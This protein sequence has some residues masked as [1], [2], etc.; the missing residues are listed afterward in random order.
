[1]RED[2]SLSITGTMSAIVTPFTKDGEIDF[3]ALEILVSG[4]IDAG[5]D[6][7]VPC[8]TTGETPALSAEEFAQVVRAVVR[9]VQGRI[10]VIAGTGSNSTKKTI[11]TTRLAKELG[12]DAALVVVPY[13]NKPGPTMQVAHF[14]SVA[15]EGGLPVVLYNV[16]GRTGINM[17]AAVTI[18]L[19]AHP[20]VIAVKEASGDLSQVQRI[21]RETK[22]SEFTVLSGD[23]ALALPMY[24]VGAH[25]VV[26]V[27]GNVV[28]RQ[29]ASIWTAW[30]SGKAEEASRTNAQLFPLFDAL[31]VETNPVPAKVALSLLGRMQ[32]TVRQPLGP[33]TSETIDA[34]RSVLRGLELL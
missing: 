28:P 10:P 27:A 33:A 34:M 5:M 22:Q 1:M 13:Y 15:N 14:Q 32:P 7:I 4:Q 17:P 31:F 29:M 3:D 11:E 26:S 21:L 12:A 25:G 16:P 23:D 6:A 2:M 30:H 19:A 20:N 8:G 24:S 18:E 9:Q